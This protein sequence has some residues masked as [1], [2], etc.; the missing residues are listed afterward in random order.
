MVFL[1]L[2]G[3]YSF[4]NKSN[5]TQR[6]SVLV[7]LPNII[8]DFPEAEETILP[9]IFK[10]VLSWDEELQVE[11]GTSLAE[12][13]SSHQLSQDAYKQLYEFILE[14]LE[15]WNNAKWD[16]VYE[17]YIQNLETIESDESKRQEI[18]DNGVK[19]SLS[20]CELSQ[21]IPSR[22]T[23]TRIMAMLSNIIDKETAK[24]KLL[25]KMKTLWHDFNF[26]VRKAITGRIDNMFNLLEKDECDKHMHDII[27]V[28]LDDEEA[29]VKNLAIEGFL[30]NINKFSQ[31]NIEENLI[32]VIT[33]LIHEI[34]ACDSP[35]DNVIWNK[36]DSLLKKNRALLKIFC[37]PVLW[38]KQPDHF[39][40]KILYHSSYIVEIF[41][42]KNFFENHYENYL[43]LLKSEETK[44]DNEESSKWFIAAD[45]HNMVKELGI[46]EWFTNDFERNI[47]YLMADSNLSAKGKLLEN[48]HIIVE[49]LHANNATEEVIELGLE[50]KISNFWTSFMKSFLKMEESLK[51]NWRY[52]NLWVDCAFRILSKMHEIDPPWSGKTDSTSST[53][54]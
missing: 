1:K 49:T 37:D 46:I 38:S 12:L 15:S 50:K 54:K 11:C 13:I 42:S 24:K 41:G 47:I 27:I 3:L 4:W 7:N 34:S 32:S 6:T 33:N 29:E 36:L 28:L 48:L 21:A 16:V 23:G 51:N 5:N 10:E 14:S 53:L 44:I 20:L 30:N 8:R 40:N 52:F 45:I 2:I 35:N 39:H 18:I 9:K 17:Q 25:P 19:L 26:E 43:V 31:K 22:W